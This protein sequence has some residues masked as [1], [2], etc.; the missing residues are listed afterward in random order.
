MSGGYHAYRV[1]KFKGLLTDRK[2]MLFI[3]VHSGLRFL[4]PIRVYRNKIRAHL[5]NA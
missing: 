3:L 5:L 4:N 2:N 1:D